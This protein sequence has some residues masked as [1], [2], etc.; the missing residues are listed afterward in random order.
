[1]SACSH[2]SCSTR[3]RLTANEIAPRVHNSGHWTIEGAVTSQFGKS[4]PRDHR[5]STRLDLPRRSPQR[6]DQSGRRGSRS[7]GVCWRSRTRTLHLYG[8]APRKGLQAGHV[9]VCT[10]DA[11]TAMRASPRSAP[12]WKNPARFRSRDRTR[13]HA[14]KVFRDP[15]KSAF[16]TVICRKSGSGDSRRPRLANRERRFSMRK[17]LRH[18]SDPRS[19]SERRHSPQYQTGDSTDRHRRHLPAHVQSARAP[20][21]TSA[22]ATR[23]SYSARSAHGV[24]ANNLSSSPKAAARRL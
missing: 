15:S 12:C 5:A 7:R 13:R 10:S 6:D 3:R 11:V 18:S 9:T 16:G 17:R 22:A 20:P 14:R 8:K 21:T 19:C 2:S 23:S 24:F 4:H 1:M